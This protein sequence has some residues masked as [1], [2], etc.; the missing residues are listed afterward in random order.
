MDGS[1][2]TFAET[3]L[4]TVLA[5]DEAPDLGAEGGGLGLA[6]A[7][8]FQGRI[9]RLGPATGRCSYTVIYFSGTS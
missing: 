4:Q 6:H 9:V 8:S 3:I 7:S 2:G 1:E 5:V